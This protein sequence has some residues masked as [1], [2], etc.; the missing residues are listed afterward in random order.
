MINIAVITFILIPSV[1]FCQ[2]IFENSL[3]DRLCGLRIEGKSYYNLGE[4]SIFTDKVNQRFTSQN[5]AKLR[6]TYKLKKLVEETS[7]NAITENNK[8]ITQKTQTKDNNNEIET[9]YFLDRGNSQMDIIGFMSVNFRDSI[10]EQRFLKLY[11]EKRI[12]ESVFMEYPVS[13]VDFAGRKIELNNSCNWMNVNSIQCPYYG[14]MN[15]SLHQS[16]EN[17]KK[18]TEIQY[19]NTKQKGIAKVIAED[20]VP[21]IFEGK[22]LIVKRTR[23]KMKVPK[24]LMEGSNELIVYYVSEE[25]RGRFIS[26][27]LSHYSNDALTENGVPALLDK[28]M[29]VKK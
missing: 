10:E 29:K 22:D 25:V 26:C 16:L 8:V 7:T 21:V 19:E 13:K 27:V 23:Y 24:F 28:V 11:V 1:L 9:Y 12:P 3:T 4:Y 5:I 18:H 15:W 6:K 17:A 20:N 14:Q 2:E